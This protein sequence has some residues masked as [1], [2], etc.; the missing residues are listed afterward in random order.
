M[1]IATIIASIAG[2]IAAILTVAVLRYL[3]Q[4]TTLVGH[5]DLQ[6]FVAH[7]V[8]WAEQTMAGAEGQQKLE[9]V[10]ERIRSVYP[11]ANDEIVITLVESYVRQLKTW[12]LLPETP[13]HNE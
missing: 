8:G 3:W 4:R 7:A 12:S 10:L 2:T 11:K 6:T 13:A 5:Q 9:A 1:D